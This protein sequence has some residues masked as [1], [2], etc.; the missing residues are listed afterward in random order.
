[1]L[2]VAALPELGEAG[3]RVEAE[4]DDEREA[5]VGHGL[6]FLR[7]EH[8]EVVARVHRRAPE[9]RELSPHHQVDYCEPQPMNS[10]L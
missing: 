7:V 1:M 4:E 9:E 8:V 3:R 2:A 10:V 5:D 6:E